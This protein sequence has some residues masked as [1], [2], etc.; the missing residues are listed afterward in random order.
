MAMAP[1]SEPGEPASDKPA[2]SLA[3]LAVALG[4]LRDSL[5]TLSLCLQ[6]CNF[7]EDVDGRHKAHQQMS[8]LLERTGSMS[9]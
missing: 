6:D 9:R 4:A 1:N 8:E 2:P 5:V 3:E 7:D